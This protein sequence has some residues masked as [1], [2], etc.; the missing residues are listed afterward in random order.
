[1]LLS[2]KVFD[3]YGKYDERFNV[4]A[5]YEFVIRIFK[6]KELNIIAINSPLVIYYAGGISNGTLAGNMNGIKWGNL[7][8]RANNIKFPCVVDLLR[9]IRSIWQYRYILTR[10]KLKLN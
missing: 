2:K 1:M 4:S 10:R 7:A 3:K 9:I 6:D 5:D 8:L